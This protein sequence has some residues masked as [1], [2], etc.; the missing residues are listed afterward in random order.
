LSPS[1]PSKNIIK[2]YRAV[3]L[4]VF[5]W[6]QNVVSHV[7]GGKQVKGIREQGAEEDIWALEGRGNKGVEKTT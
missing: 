3:I 1:F 6:A 7:Q 2:I 5:V 4:P